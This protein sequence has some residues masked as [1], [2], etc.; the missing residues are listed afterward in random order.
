MARL[1]RRAGVG[2]GISSW[3]AASF[4][5][6]WLTM[7][8]GA[9]L[10]RRLGLADPFFDPHDAAHAP[11]AR[12]RAPADVRSAAAGVDVDVARRAA[13]ARRPGVPRAAVARSWRAL[14]TPVAVFLLQA[15][16]LWVWHIP[17]WYEAALRSDGHPRAWSTCASSSRRHCSGGRWCTADTAGWPTASRVLYVFLTAVHS[18]ALGALLTVSPSCGTAST[19]G[20]PPPG[21]S[22]RSRISSSPAS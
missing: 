2:R 20:R 11:D 22:M 6:G 21:T 18:S 9:G 1:W 17:S 12:R 19:A 10:S 3:S 16:A 8:R 13:A 7:V 5:A 4:A 14:T 15:V